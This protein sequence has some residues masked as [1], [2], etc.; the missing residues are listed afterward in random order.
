MTRRS[1]REV[2]LASV[3]L[4]LA[5]GAC[6]SKGSKAHVTGAP[7]PPELLSLSALEYLT[8]AAACERI[9]PRDE[10]P[11]ALD[12][13][14]P[15]YVDHALW[16]AP[17]A[18]GWRAQFRSGLGKLDAHARA[19]HA[20]AFWELTAAQ[21]DEILGEWEAA[22]ST[23]RGVFFRKL[24]SATLEGA[25][26]DPV[27]GGNDKAGGWTLVAA[28]RDPFAPALPPPGWTPS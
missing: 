11:G 27:Y 6:T 18:P 9:L 8:L 24:V 19:R 5:V 7:L 20:V 26:C 3:P 12:L 25:M 1:R 13:Q 23:E 2:I 4:A 15:R 28:R 16:A 22:R 10:T 17:R 21:Q 14:V